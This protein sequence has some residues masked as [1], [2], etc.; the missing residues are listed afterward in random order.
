MYF[1]L[2]GSLCFHERS[3]F[4]FVFV[5]MVRS[6]VG[7]WIETERRKG[8]EVKRKSLVENGFQKQQ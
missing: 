5:S 2:M 7:F 6:D 1:P 3:S 4:I 8:F